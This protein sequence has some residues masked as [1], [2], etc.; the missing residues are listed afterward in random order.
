MCRLILHKADQYTWLGMNAGADFS[1]CVVT[2]PFHWGNPRHLRVGAG[3]WIL[4]AKPLQTGDGTGRRVLA[5]RALS[6]SH[7]QQRRRR[8]ALVQRRRV[9]AREVDG[10]AKHFAL[11]PRFG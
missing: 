1:I 10:L 9:D 2:N 7:E 5:S 11:S 6:V 8:T 3:G 4:F